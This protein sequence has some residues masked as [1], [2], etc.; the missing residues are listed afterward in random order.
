MSILL[1]DECISPRILPRLREL[2]IDAIHVRERGMSGVG[3]HTIWRYAQE[4]GR[5]VLTI[6]KVD[7]L[8]LAKASK[9][10]SGLVILPNGGRPDSQFDW[11]QAAL[12]WMATSNTG[13]GFSNRYIEVS[14]D[15]QIVLAEIICSEAA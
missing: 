12:K 13:M 7:F 2:G 4:N 14:E 3:D 1:V 5:T 6:N 11:I 9:E 10:H 8:K 15:G